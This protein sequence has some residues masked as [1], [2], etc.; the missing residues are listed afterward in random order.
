MQQAGLDSTPFTN[1]GIEAQQDAYPQHTWP[2]FLIL[3]G[4]LACLSALNRASGGTSAEMLVTSL[5][6]WVTNVGAA[7]CAL[8]S[9]MCAPV[10][11]TALSEFAMGTVKVFI[12][13]GVI[14][15]F[16]VRPASLAIGW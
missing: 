10:G 4:I 3:A 15:Y 16:L 14:G 7:A 9:A 1:P 2:A 13:G 12:V 5:P 6:L 11:R 8:T